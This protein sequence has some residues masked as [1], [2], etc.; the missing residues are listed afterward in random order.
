MLERSLRQA[1]IYSNGS[2]DIFVKRPISAGLLMIAFLSLTSPVFR[3][4]Y[5]KM[6]TGILRHHK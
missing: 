6:K 5:K 4:A 1:L 3:M 2:L